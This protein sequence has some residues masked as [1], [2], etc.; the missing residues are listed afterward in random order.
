M[1]GPERDS[2]GKSSFELSKIEGLTPIPQQIEKF[3]N[4]SKNKIMFQE[5]AARKMA[6]LA[7]H[8]KRIVLSGVV[9]DGIEKSVI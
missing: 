1:K 7:S 8:H 9:I 5:Y 4:S 2:R 3:W 6:T